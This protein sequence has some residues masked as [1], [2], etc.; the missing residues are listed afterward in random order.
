[1]ISVDTDTF[2]SIPVKN[3]GTKDTY[4]NVFKTEIDRISGIRPDIKSSIRMPYILAEHGGRISGIW[5]DIKSSVRMPYIL[6]EHGGR[7]IGIRPRL[8]SDIRAIRYQVHVYTVKK[9]H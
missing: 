5:S 6:G 4:T 2:A 1:M 8:G 3:T 9:D 7:I